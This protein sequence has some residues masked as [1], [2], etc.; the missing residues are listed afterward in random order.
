MTPPGTT[1]GTPVF[2]I[3][4]PF[5]L[6]GRIDIGALR[7][8]LA[9]LND[10]S[11]PALIVNGTT[12]EFPSLDDHE[13]DLVLEAC[14]AEF[15][16]RLLVNVSA[17]DPRAVRATMERQAL[18]SD[19]FL[20]LPP[21]YLA[22]PPE[23]GLSAFFRRA[24]TGTPRLVYLYNFPRHTQAP[25]TPALLRSLIE[26]GL[27]IAGVKDSSGS[28]ENATVYRDGVPGLA[29]Y[30]GSDSKALAALEAGLA[31][32]TSGGAACFP[33]FLVALTEAFEAGDGPQAQALQAH[34]D[35]WTMFRKSLACSE[36]ALVKAALAERLPGF[37]TTVR[38]PLV[39]ADGETAKRVRREV[40]RLLARFEELR[41]GR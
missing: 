4:T 31:G 6:D 17:T 40:R 36:P 29:V 23:E 5:G 2:A 19:A 24:L 35:Q 25:I 34:A 26:E 21:Y 22:D 37:P 16:G 28:M 18:A 11:V 15:R 9:L 14:R 27:P 30:L 13:K 8:Y 32:S 10:A 39:A 20:V 7:E 3:V 12:G 33:E 38:P 41:I 1:L